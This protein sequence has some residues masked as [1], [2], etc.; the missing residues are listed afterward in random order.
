MNSVPVIPK[1]LT[2][3]FILTT[4]LF[5]LWGFP[6]DLTNPMVEVFKNV[7]DISNVKASYVQLAF[8]GGYGTMAIPAALYI[9][10]YSYKSGIVLGL[11][12][13][14]IGSFMMFPAAQLISYD[15][16]LISFYVLT[17][18]L[19]FLETTANPMILAMGDPSTATQRLNLAQA[20]N[21]IG[22]LA[23]QVVAR[24]FVVDRLETEIGAGATTAMDMVD[25]Q[26]I[27]A[28]DLNVVSAPY[29]ILGGVVLVVLVTFLMTDIK[30]KKSTDVSLDLKT[31]MNYLFNNKNYYEGV[32]AQFFYVACQIMVWTFIYQYVTAINADRPADDQLNA[33][34]YVVASTVC[35]LLAR[36][37]CTFM[38][39]YISSS[40]LMYYF[41][42][43]GILFLIGAIVIDGMVG[44]YCLVGVSFAM[45]LMFPTIYGIAL[46]GMGDEAKIGSAGL[47]LAIVG[48]ALMPPLQ[49]RIIDL[50]GTG[51]NDI[52]YFGFIPE[53]RFSFVL[54]LLCMLVV[55]IYAKRSENRK[56]L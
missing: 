42:L 17:F 13:F 52:S 44:L 21:P 31:T 48:G 26:A 47:I 54:P 24:V 55:A 43:L 11:F 53:I 2:L 32:I 56:A 35:F 19:A 9:R 33:M 8:Y 34:A 25:K 23:G 45:S 15:L 28:H 27:I 29:L 16:F 36:W 14:A 50:G 12:L 1:S 37:V 10:K 7:L 5:F 40:K 4:S 6:N 46:S 39:R 49:A 38:I 20:F 22:A 3:A 41:A 30:I 18:G 51:L